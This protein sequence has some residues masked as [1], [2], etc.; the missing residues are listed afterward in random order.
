MSKSHKKKN[1]SCITIQDSQ[2]F[3]KASRRMLD[4]FRDY[5]PESP[6]PK[7]QLPKTLGKY[8]IHLSFGEREIWPRKIRSTLSKRQPSSSATAR[9]SCSFAWTSAEAL[10]PR[11]A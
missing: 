8:D 1:L 3:S 7:I 5:L 2:S 6:S 11:A 4:N 9:D 10:D